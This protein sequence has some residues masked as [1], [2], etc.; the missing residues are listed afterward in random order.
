MNGTCLSADLREH[1]SCA[2]LG[3]RKALRKILRVVYAIAAAADETVERCPIGLAKF[4]ERGMCDLRFG[5]ALPR[6]EYHAPMGRR[7]EITAGM[8]VPGQDF[9]VSG[10]YQDHRKKASR[11]KN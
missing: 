5:L 9:H 7:K 8:P 2:R 1:R 11:Q 10:L 6:R 4:R 3:R